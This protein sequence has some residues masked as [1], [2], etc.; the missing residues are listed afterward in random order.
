MLKEE[1]M[2]MLEKEVTNQEPKLLVPQ[3]QGI[4]HF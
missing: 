3:M 1:Q 2:V 4:D